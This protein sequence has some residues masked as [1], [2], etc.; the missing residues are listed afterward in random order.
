MFW[1][2]FVLL[3]GRGEHSLSLSLF[4]DGGRNWTLEFGFGL[5]EKGRGGGRVE[6]GCIL[7]FSGF[8]FDERTNERKYPLRDIFM[9]SAI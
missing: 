5:E 1:F 8:F 2:L 9:N 4:L 7:K 3:R 6:G